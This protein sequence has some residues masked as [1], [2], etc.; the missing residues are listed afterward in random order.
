MQS[1]AMANQVAR[2]ADERW[3]DI[4]YA[5][6]LQPIATLRRQESRSDRVDSGLDSW[7][8]AVVG[9]AP[10]PSPNS[11]HIGIDPLTPT[12]LAVGVNCV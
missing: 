5:P 8:I 11:S 10:P 7:S 2:L 4:R 1:H 12:A 3:D 9:A 6:P